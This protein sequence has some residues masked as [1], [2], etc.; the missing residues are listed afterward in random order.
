MEEL[1]SDDRPDRFRPTKLSD[2]KAEAK[3]IMEERR[4]QPGWMEKLRSKLK[5]IKKTDPNIYPLY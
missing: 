5:N 4:K 1:M 2:L 3:K